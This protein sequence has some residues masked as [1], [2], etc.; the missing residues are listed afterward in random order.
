MSSARSRAARGFTLLEVMCA[1]AILALIT[2]FIS[3]TCHEAME[4]GG[5]AGDLRA[6]REAADTVFRRLCYEDGLHADGMR[7]SL[8]DF[9]AAWAELPS[10]QRDRWTPYQM[11]FRRRAR[12]A[13]GEATAE[14]GEPLVG[15]GSSSS[16]SRGSGGTGG[17][18]TGGTGTGGTGT[19]G[20]GTGG[21]G[22]ASTGTASGDED[23]GSSVQ[24]ME[25]TLTIWHE[26]AEEEPLI[27]L[28]TLVP[29]QAK[30]G[31]AGGTGSRA[32]SPR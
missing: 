23:E 17:T 21:T 4:R 25:L 31:K 11:G 8:A 19:G 16:R 27:V 1:F 2:S 18:G 6:L 22:G 10:V 24:L 3:Q 13:A 20:T 9:Y 29:P 7:A 28:Q 30:D 14:G 26:D 12:T 15:S 5:R 32:G